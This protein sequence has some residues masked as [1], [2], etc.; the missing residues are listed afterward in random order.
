MKKH[1]FYLPMAVVLLS[2]VGL[3]INISTTMIYSNLPMYMKNVLGASAKTT[4][5][6]DGM[7]EFISYLTRIASGV[8][9]DF[10]QNRKKVLVFGYGLAVLSK[11][12]YLFASN[13][14]IVF[15]AQAINR[16][17][18]GTIASPRDALVGDVTSEKRRGASYGFM[19]SMKTIGSVFGAFIGMGILFSFSSNHNAPDHNDFLIV[20]TIATIPAFISFIILV[21]FIKEPKNH[22]ECYEH[23]DALPSPTQDNGPSAFLKRHQNG[24]I[25]VLSLITA[26]TATLLSFYHVLSFV[27]WPVTFCIGWGLMIAASR[28]YPNLHSILLRLFGYLLTLSAILSLVFACDQTISVLMLGCGLLIWYHAAKNTPTLFAQ[29]LSYVL[30]GIFLV[31]L[32]Y[33]SYGEIVHLSDTTLIAPSSYVSLFLALLGL[34]FLGLGLYNFPEPE[35]IKRARQRLSMPFWLIIIVA[36]VFEMTHF[37]ES[38]LTWRAN[39]A[40]LPQSLGPLVMVAMNIGQFLVAYPLG[41]L[42]DRYNRRLILITGFIFMIFAN[43]LMGFGTNFFVVMLGIFFW[44]AQMS[45]TQSIFLSLISDVVEKEARATAF[46]IFYFMTGLCYLASST[47]AGHLWDT[48]GYQYSFFTSIGFA[49]AAIVAALFLLN[50]TYLQR[51]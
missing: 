3:L 2:A 34:V 41:Y 38:L 44:G 45:T 1:L 30:V 8:I 16:F 33:F 7:V 19:R 13:V 51:K 22:R 10:M 18:N 35:N 20:F 48:Y 39:E 37:S 23:H 25:F 36:V 50:P 17:A 11:P 9:S 46:G 28:P 40:G 43:V 6:I 4:A 49:S 5:F 42:S 29:K 24:G 31:L 47:L 26:L 14:M 27:S 12:L 15:I 21:F 32:G